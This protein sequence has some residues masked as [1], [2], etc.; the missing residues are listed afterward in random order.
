MTDVIG[1]A[2]RRTDAASER[3]LAGRFGPA[4]F[5]ITVARFPT[6]SLTSMT[7]TN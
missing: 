7:R 5:V 6:T 1:M 4:G 3:V 2:G